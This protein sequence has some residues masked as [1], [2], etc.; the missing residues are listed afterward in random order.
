[1]RIYDQHIGRVYEDGSIAV[2]DSLSPRYCKVNTIGYF[3]YIEQ[4]RVAGACEPSS[5]SR[6]VIRQLED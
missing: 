2:H 3:L 5:P 1:M 6:T 4:L